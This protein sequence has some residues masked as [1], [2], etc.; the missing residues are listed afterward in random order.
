MQQKHGRMVLA[1][2]IITALLLTACS[3][4]TSKKD[5]APAPSAPSP[6]APQKVTLHVLDQFT[7]GSGGDAA[8]K[9]LYAEFNQKF[10]HIE[11]KR[12]TLPFSEMNKVLKTMLASGTGPDL[13]YYEVG[14]G[15]TGSLIKANLFEPLNEYAA[16][17]KWR[18]KLYKSAFEWTTRDGKLWGM[19]TEIEFVG[20]YYN[21]TLLDKEGLKVPETFPQLLDFCTAAKGK[22]YVPV[23][24]SQN[25]GWQAYHLIAMT[26]TNTVG[27][28]AM[29][30]LLFDRKGSWNTPEMTKAIKA[31]VDMEKAGCFAPDINGLLYADSNALF[32]SGKA[33]LNTTG[34]WRI[35][36]ITKA[37][38]G[39]FDIQ[40]APFPAMDKGRYL[41]TG[42][43]SAWYISAD[44]KQK[45]AAAEFINFMYETAS[46]KTWAEV[47]SFVTPGP[48]DYSNMQLSPL[49]KFAI[50]N[51]QAKDA[52]FG[53]YVDLLATE[54]LNTMMRP[55][56]QAVVAGQ[57]T[58]EAM[59][60]E[61]QSVWEKS[62]N[63]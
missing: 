21:K 48:Y 39:K 28:D 59:A 49:L 41:A 63:K 34:T 62:I 45:D 61:M 44:S 27:P 24:H 18:D 43:G 47:A 17:Y 5:Q 14:P 3:S 35:G 1:L 55:G 42:M 32:E 30:D 33:L 9:K 51:L 12:E 25:P 16:K 37:T 57:K 8:A 7:D 38:G 29:R 36:P 15:F 56:F 26:A 2:S 50:S 40:I 46:V 22:G 31:F 13:V 20:M 6:A 54:E 53:Y 10:P 23:A 52:K 58:P 4:A 19:P 60:A 11:I